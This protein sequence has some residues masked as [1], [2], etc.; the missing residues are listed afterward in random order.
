MKFY[1]VRNEN[2]NS[3]GVVDEKGELK[4]GTWGPSDSDGN[5][6]G[7]IDHNYG[8]ISPCP[9]CGGFDLCANGTCLCSN[10]W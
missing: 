5:S 1:V 3:I 10:S 6:C 8:E 2:G 9:E 7:W 4:A